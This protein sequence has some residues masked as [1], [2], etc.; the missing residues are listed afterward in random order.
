VKKISKPPR[1]QF[2]PDVD[3]ASIPI[4]FL[5]IVSGILTDT[6][7]TPWINA[8][9]SVNAISLSSQ[10]VFIN[11]VAVPT[12]FGNLDDTGAFNAYVPRTD[13]VQPLGCT[14]QFTIHSVTSQAPTVVGEIT[15]TA[16]TLNLGGLLSP[17]V[18]PRIHAGNLVYAYSQ[19]EVVNPQ[20]GNGY[21]N[22]SNLL[23]YLWQGFEWVPI[24]SGPSGQIYPPIGIAVSTGSAWGTSIDPATVAYRNQ[25]N[26]F[27][28][29]QIAG[30]GLIATN[31]VSTL[32][33][34]AVRLMGDGAS[35][36]LVDFIG[37]NAATAGIGRFRC[38]SADGS[39]VT[40]MLDM[41]AGALTSLVSVQA[42]AGLNVA[43]GNTQTLANSV[44]ISND[45]PGPIGTIDFVGP[46]AA[47]E[48]TGR[49]RCVSPTFFPA[50]V[51]MEFSAS[52]GVTVPVDFTCTGTKNFRIPHPLDPTKDLIHSC[53]E[54]PE[55]AVYYRGEG[56][57]SAGVATIA[58]PDYFEALTR[59]EDR[60]VQIT[61]LVEDDSPTFGGQLAAGRVSNGK[62]NVYSEDAAQKFYW[63][64]KAIRS[65]V[66]ALEVVR[67][68]K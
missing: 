67:D 66:P 57:T 50:T 30:A 5:C 49:I 18:A 60:T 12:M 37:P 59:K 41:S 17:I 20:N 2:A 46:D 58:L 26:T 62:F 45:A 33:A 4:E 68:G 11:G 9:W 28:A 24:D 54:G 35:G 47:T 56:E 21:V 23:A 31:Q 52:T 29:Q 13:F 40:E 38:L 14:L 63:E 44:R 7:G 39:V 16:P 6:D 15:V 43:N 53:L 34:N 51:M 55:A 64:V 32:V 42:G 10:P 8:P 27:T 48:G 3:P 19:L 36:G 61:A 65:D 1:A 25:P 22:T